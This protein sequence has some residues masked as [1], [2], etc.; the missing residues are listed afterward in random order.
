MLATPLRAILLG[1]GVTFGAFALLDFTGCSSG[2]GPR[3]GAAGETCTRTD[4]CME[5]LSCIDTVCTDP[6]AIPDGGGGGGSGGS[7]T[8]GAPPLP[9]AGPWSACGEC[10]DTA[11]SAELA[12][13]DVECIGI[14]ACIETVCAHLSAIDAPAE[15]G[16]CQVKC[17][18]EHPDAKDAHLAVVNC[19]NAAS[20]GPPCVPYPDDF[21]ACR[22]Y[23]DKGPCKSLR[24]TCVESSDCQT[25]LDCVS[26]CTTFKDCIACDDSPS[27]QAGRKILQDYQTC[28]ASECI[29]ASWL[30]GI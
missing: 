24:A 11:C 14:E 28:L 6:S 13:C 1:L 20:C 27:G 23:M 10:L 21:D 25:Y 30:P 22:K 16:A 8:G 15:E 19:A 5:P 29:L 9:D 7:G 3:K 17:Q 26:A 2:D 4:D 12:A 18:Q